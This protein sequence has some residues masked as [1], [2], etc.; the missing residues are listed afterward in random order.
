MKRSRALPSLLAL[1]LTTG[2][3]LALPST[4]TAAPTATAVLA[5]AGPNIS[6]DNVKT[7]L[8]QFQNI[9]NNNGGRR[10]ST[11]AGYTA[12]VN[13]VYDKL[14]A[15]GYSV[16]KQSCTSGCTT[17]AGPNV[18]AEWPAGDPNQVLMLGAHLDSVS[19]G[20]GINDNAS[21]SSLLLE[22]ALTLARQNPTMAKRVR[23]AWWTDEEQ[24]LRGSKFYVNSLTSTQRS[25]ITGYLNFDM[26]ASPNGGYFINRIT[27]SLG[28]TLK[29]YYDSIGVPTEENTEGAG[30]SDDAPF[31]AV[32]IQ[33]S[34]VAAGAGYTKTS[35]QATKWGGTAG[36]PY[37]PCYHRS[38]D[39][40]PSNINTTILDRAAD[41]SAHALWTLAVG[42]GGGSICSGYQSTRTGT[43]SSGTSVYHPNGSYFYTGASG[44]HDACLDGPTGTDF[45]LYLQKWNGSSWVTVA[46]GITSGPDETLSYTGTAGYYRYRVHAYS[47]SGAYTLGYTSP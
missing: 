24:G 30:R 32:G 25:R 43:L 33:T 15:A 36:Q 18:I 28:Q 22:L 21:G 31:N 17:G 34:G 2:S 38:C 10:N 40:Y 6:I 20:P 19:A 14:V 27:S 12:S 4:A 16:T 41:A 47:G 42:S 29:S 45:D 46:Q 7:H 3:L 35:A 8:Q 23:F 1:A 9:A 37:D 5:A 39:S 11:S 26:V 44:R 13:Y